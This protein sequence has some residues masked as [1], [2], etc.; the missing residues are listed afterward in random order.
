MFHL[1]KHSTQYFSEIVRRYH[2]YF[3]SKPPYSR[4]EKE[5]HIRLWFRFSYKQQ[6]ERAV[7]VETQETG[8]ARVGKTINCRELH[9]T[10]IDRHKYVVDPDFM[11]FR[12]AD[13][14]TQKICFHFSSH[15]WHSFKNTAESFTSVFGIFVTGFFIYKRI[16]CTP[17]I[18]C[19]WWSSISRSC[20]PVMWWNT[21]YRKILKEKLKHAASDSFQS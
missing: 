9:Y 7:K 10:R 6:E 15:P 4:D 16:L 5:D 1:N 8:Q 17:N 11:L 3:Q 2:L 13:S 12:C 19:S 18:Q 21:K 14:S 20:K